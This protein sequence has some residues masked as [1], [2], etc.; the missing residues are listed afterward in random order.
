MT[1]T[2]RQ[3]ELNSDFG[4]VIGTARTRATAERKDVQEE[5]FKLLIVAYKINNASIYPSVINVSLSHS[6]S[7]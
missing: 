7:V 5:F 1:F 2:Q 3:S 6:N 4:S